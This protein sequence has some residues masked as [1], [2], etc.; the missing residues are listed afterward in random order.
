MRVVINFAPSALAVIWWQVEEVLLREVIARKTKFYKKST[1]SN[2]QAALTTK[3]TTSE[4]CHEREFTQSPA[5][6][7]VIS[8][9]SI[10]TR[11]QPRCNIFCTPPSPAVG[12]LR[13]NPIR[14]NQTMPPSQCRCNTRLSKISWATG[15]L[16]DGI[17]E[18]K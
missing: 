13:N 9:N 12:R 3:M 17:W 1:S 2:K 14:R 6:S 16:R 18:I 11:S 15:V 7:S 5:K 4:S 10:R 8:I